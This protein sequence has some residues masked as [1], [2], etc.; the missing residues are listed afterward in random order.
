M[1]LEIFME[2]HRETADTNGSEDSSL[3]LFVKLRSMYVALSDKKKLKY[4][5]KAEEQ[6]DSTD[7]SIIYI[8]INYLDFIF[9]LNLFIKLKNKPL[10][11]S[12]LSKHEIQLLF[13]SYGMPEI[14]PK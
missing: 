12:F 1:P 10:F 11:T 14:V 6:Y 8:N 2:K 3:S 13:E 4:I 9:T 5:K 7:V